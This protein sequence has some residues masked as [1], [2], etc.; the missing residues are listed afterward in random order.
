MEKICKRCDGLTL[1]GQR[2]R[3]RASCKIGCYYYC[4]H[5]APEYIRKSASNPSSLCY[6]TNVLKKSSG[7]GIKTIRQRPRAE[8]PIKLVAPPAHMNQGVFVGKSLIPGA[9]NG[10]FANKKFEQ[11]DIVTTFGGSLIWAD[12]WAKLPDEMR[13]YAKKVREYDLVI[14]GRV[15]YGNQKG[16]WM[17]HR[18]KNAN[19][20]WGD[21]KK[22]SGDSSGMFMPIYAKR[23][24]EPGEEILINY[25]KGFAE[26]RGLL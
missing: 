5:H 3:N 13:N 14:D 2:C 25:G 1:L 22:V 21:L 19:V 16:R 10:L 23:T 24:I 15:G 18:S 12:E 17:N 11:G 7:K 6:R 20:E 8:F 4:W 9:G 26:T